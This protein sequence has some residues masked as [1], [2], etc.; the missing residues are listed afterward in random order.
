MK[1]CGKDE[2]KGKESFNSEFHVLKEWWLKSLIE[3]GS[4]Y[5]ISN[6]NRSQ[7]KK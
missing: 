1:G 3:N 4:Q 6:E 2:A 7:L 5:T